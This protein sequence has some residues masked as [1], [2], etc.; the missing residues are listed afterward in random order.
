MILKRISITLTL[1]VIINCASTPRRTAIN[2]TQV[3]FTALQTA[4]DI[5]DAAFVAKQISSEDRIIFS[6]IYLVTALELNK[7]IVILI[8][9]NSSTLNSEFDRFSILTF[10]TVNNFIEVLSNSEFNAKLS[11]QVK[12][13]FSIIAN[14]KAYQKEIHVST[15]FNF[16]RVE[17]I[18]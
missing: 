17:S 1:L 8:Q 15:N 10:N 9:T 12:L 6:K 7:Q 11:A 14:W 2:Y 16:N 3:L 5:A 4:R 13:I 18:I